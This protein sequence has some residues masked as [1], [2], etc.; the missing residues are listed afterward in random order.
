MA[1]R[2]LPRS[3]VTGELRHP[4]TIHALAGTDAVAATDVATNVPM[5]ITVV[6]LAFQQRE[7]LDAGGLRTQTLYNIACRY[8]TDMKAAYVLVEQCCTQRTFQIVA[9]IPSERKDA[10]DMTCVTNG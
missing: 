2:T 4:M 7:L 9:I 5:K 6:P 8:R 1:I 10:L 3:F